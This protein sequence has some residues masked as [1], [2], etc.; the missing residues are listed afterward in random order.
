MSERQTLSKIGLAFAL[1]AVASAA[2]QNSATTQP[3][4]QRHGSSQPTSTSA[5]SAPQVGD[6]APLFKLKTLDGKRE[7]E[8]ASLRGKRPVLLLFG[9]YT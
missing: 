5:P 9:S 3:A 4:E 6:V 2:G 7:V 8:L 1:L